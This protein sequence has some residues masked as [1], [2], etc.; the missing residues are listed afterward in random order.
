[1]LFYLFSPDNAVVQ[2]C[3]SDMWVTTSP[4]LYVP[5]FCTYKYS[6]LTSQLLVV[7]EEQNQNKDPSWWERDAVSTPRWRRLPTSPPTTRMTTTTIIMSSSQVKVLAWNEVPFLCLSAHLMLVSSFHAY[8][9]PRSSDLCLSKCAEN[10]KLSLLKR[11][12]FSERS[13]RFEFLLPPKHQIMP[14]FR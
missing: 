2:N 11:P 14:G 12:P 7:S 9:R 5:T 8:R 6:R 3:V 4:K 13:V 1:M 10:L